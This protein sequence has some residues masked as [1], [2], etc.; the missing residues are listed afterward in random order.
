MTS[1]RV[2]Q[3]GFESVNTSSVE[4]G[5]LLHDNSLIYSLQPDLP[6]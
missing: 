6:T 1:Q 3:K 5:S 4:L 2:K